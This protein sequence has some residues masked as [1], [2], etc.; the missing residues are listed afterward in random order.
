MQGI[1]TS[2]SGN[3][4]PSG[5]AL[6]CLPRPIAVCFQQVVNLGSHQSRLVGPHLTPSLTT[7]AGKAPWLPPQEKGQ[8]YTSSISFRPCLFANAAFTYLLAASFG[9]RLTRCGEISMPLPA[10]CK[11]VVM[12]SNQ[13]AWRAFVP[14]AKPT[15]ATKAIKFTIGF[16]P[17]TKT[18]FTFADVLGVSPDFLLY[19]STD[20]KAKARLSDP[21]L[22]NQFKAIEAM[23]EDDRNVVKKLID[24]FITKKQ[25]QKLAQ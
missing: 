24:A 5:R 18:D 6:L 2:F 16:T 19:G 23:E 15:R 3:M 20:E 7:P 11:F 8:G 4:V 21:E 9:M 1:N 12:A 14:G 25:V 13:R 10:P 17:A 22:I